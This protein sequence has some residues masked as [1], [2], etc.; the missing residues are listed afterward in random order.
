MSSS[1]ERTATGLGAS[2]APSSCASLN[3][4]STPRLPGS[5]CLS[6]APGVFGR[7]ALA[8]EP[9]GCAHGVG[10][11]F[12]RRYVTTA[13]GTTQMRVELTIGGG[14]DVSRSRMLQL[15]GV[16]LEV[17]AAELQRP[18]RGCR[19]AHVVLS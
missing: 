10:N 16:W 2:R 12:D 17:R 18:L 14:G 15:Q 13:G 11:Q 4:R 9:D 1:H 7:T 6:V 3:L 8:I 5:Q 19:A